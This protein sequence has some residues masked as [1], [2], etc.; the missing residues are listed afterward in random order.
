MSE[1]IS[2]L[3]K[4]TLSRPTWA[5]V[6]NSL[7]QM[8]YTLREIE[9]ICGL[10]RYH[11]H[12]LMDEIEN[13]ESAY[14]YTKIEKQEIELTDD[15]FAFVNKFLEDNPEADKNEIYNAFREK[16]PSIKCSVKELTRKLENAGYYMI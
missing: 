7:L 1:N 3:G 13:L 11:V 5:V 12:I 8:G 15:H 9:K 2:N 14:E 4:I 6:I 10:T 16:Y